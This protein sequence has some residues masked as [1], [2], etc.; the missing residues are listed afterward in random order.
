MDKSL[1][2]IVGTLLI[3]V[4]GA[5]SVYTS[6]MAESRSNGAGHDHSKV[7]AEEKMQSRCASDKNVETPEMNDHAS[8]S[9]ARTDSLYSTQDGAQLMQEPHL[10]YV[11]SRP[12]LP[13]GYGG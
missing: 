13:P 5:M 10:K 7:C 3:G 9:P 11:D 4:P 6:A 8:Q 2:A 1:F 12:D